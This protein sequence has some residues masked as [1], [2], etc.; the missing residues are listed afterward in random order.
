[1]S[2]TSVLKARMQIA[3]ISYKQA[4]ELSIK[5]VNSDTQDDVKALVDEFINKNLRTQKIDAPYD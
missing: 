3:K 1:M 5:A 4:K 2:A